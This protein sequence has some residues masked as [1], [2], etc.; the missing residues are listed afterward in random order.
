VKPLV[1][2]LIASIAPYEPGK[3]I[4]E[5]H[6]ELGA[7]WPKEGAI[8]L[9]SNENPL[10]PSPKAVEAAREAMGH[11]HLYPDGGGFYLRQALSAHLKVDANQI[12]LGSGSNELI[13]LIIQ[14]YCELDEE[15][16]APALSFACYRLSAD[17]HRRP[18]REAP[19]GPGFAYDLDAL[20]DNVGPKTKL[21]F[22]G[23]P[24]NPTGVYADRAAFARLVERLPADVLLVVDEAYF[25]YARATDYP[26][27]L[28]LLPRRERMMT[29]RTFSKIYGL[30]GLRVGYAVGPAHVVEYLHRT[31]LAFNVNAIGQIAAK[32]ALGDVEHLER[33]RR[34]NA[35][36]LPRLERQLAELGLGVTPSQTNFILVDCHRPARSIYDALLRR[37]VIVRP[38]GPYSLPNHLRITVGTPAENDRLLAA[39][40][41]VL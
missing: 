29:L 12:V 13:D 26:D 28:E 6:R 1:S 5:L 23:N 36:E 25:E 30:A 40:R 14:T 41:E 7:S 22:L 33:S 18:F 11:A 37:G 2:P 8:K 15:V 39:L 21:V 4:E 9:A 3:P 17:A 16:L 32:A 31:R 19:L 20:V 24:N 10:G 27:A 38:M 35:A 34:A